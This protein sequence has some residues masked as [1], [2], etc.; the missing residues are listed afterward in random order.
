MRKSQI[1]DVNCSFI[2]LSVVVSRGIAEELDT[3]HE[4][5][6]TEEDRAGLVS[7]VIT[8]ATVNK[9]PMSYAME[10]IRFIYFT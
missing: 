10:I 3:D 4:K 6:F 2:K 7:D 5:Y 1:E 9:C 8:M